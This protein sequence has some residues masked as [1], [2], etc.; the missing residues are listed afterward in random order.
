[1]ELSANQILLLVALLMVAHFIADFL[2]G[3]GNKQ[4]VAAKKDGKPFWP[5]AW[6][7]WHHMLIMYIVFI[8]FQKA[9]GHEVPN[10]ILAMLNIIQF[11]THLIIDWIKT[12]ISL[13]WPIWADKTKRWYWYL[14]GFDQLCH[15]VVI[16]GMVCIYVRW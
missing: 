2:M 15:Q 16:I 14:L 3:A 7:A 4:I 1:M 13:K 9:T 5:F 12:Q 8:F 6:H 11:C 10:V